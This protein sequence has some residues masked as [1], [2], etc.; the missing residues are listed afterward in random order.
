ME[1]AEVFWLSRTSCS[2]I[3]ATVRED[4]YRGTMPKV[5]H[6][7]LCRERQVGQL[8]CRT[9]KLSANEKASMSIGVDANL[10]PKV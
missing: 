8:Y 3:A 9:A 1:Q 5:S 7:V 6:E 2:T 10:L 4:A